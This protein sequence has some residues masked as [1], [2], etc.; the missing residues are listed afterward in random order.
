MGDG[1][2]ADGAALEARPQCLILCPITMD[3]RNTQTTTSE[4]QHSLAVIPARKHPLY[5]FHVVSFSFLSG[6]RSADRHLML[7]LGNLLC[8]FF[9]LFT[10]G[11]APL[12]GTSRFSTW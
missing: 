1:R 10:R 11:Y 3:L 12:L 6:Q 7:S 2:R 5:R 9:L 4:L 8:C